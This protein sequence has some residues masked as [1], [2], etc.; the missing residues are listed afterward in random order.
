MLGLEK[1][2]ND[3]TLSYHVG[4]E[5]FSIWHLLSLFFSAHYYYYH[6]LSVRK[7]MAKMVSL[8]SNSKAVVVTGQPFSAN[9]LRS[10]S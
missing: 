9:E 4:V 10:G 3:P 6:D 2:A 5:L 8:Q 1:R 7:E